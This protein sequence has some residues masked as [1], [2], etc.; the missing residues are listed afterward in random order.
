MGVSNK[1][2]GNKLEEDICAVFGLHRWW[3]TNL[4]QGRTGQ[5]ADIIATRN[6]NAVL[7]DAKHCKSKYFDTTRMEF[8]Q[9]SAMNKWLDTNNG[10]CGFVLEFDA[11][12]GVYWVVPFM[13]LKSRYPHRV[14]IEE[15]TSKGELIETFMRRIAKDET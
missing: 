3:A 11:Y 1:S 12:P 4:A 10:Y 7:L 8:N 9:I 2:V 6:G 5:P 13:Y 15:V 14:S